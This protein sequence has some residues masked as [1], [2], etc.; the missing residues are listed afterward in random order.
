MLVETF[1]SDT[2]YT[3][4][5]RKI[6]NCIYFVIQPFCQCIISVYSTKHKISQINKNNTKCH[7]IVNIFNK[8]TPK[9]KMNVSIGEKNKT[10]F[11]QCHMVEYPLL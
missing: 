7:S 6:H 8:K 11:R 1:K 3:I 2:K 10:S 9:S 4:K 5:C